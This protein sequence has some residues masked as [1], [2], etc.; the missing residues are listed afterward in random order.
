M[1]NTII[2]F[3]CHNCGQTKRNNPHSCSTGYGTDAKGNK[4]CFNCIAAIDS[5]E[6]ANMQPGE[7][8]IHYYSN[9]KITNWPGSLVIITLYKKTG[10]HN[11]AV[12]RTDIWF[13]PG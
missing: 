1:S 4:L 5:D 6:L 13:T 8:T 10:K 12:K 7:K 11:I 3:T 2:S 9:G